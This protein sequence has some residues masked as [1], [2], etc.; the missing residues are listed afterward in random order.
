MSKPSPYGIL[1][2]SLFGEV[3]DVTVTLAQGNFKYEVLETV[4]DE[5][6]IGGPPVPRSKFAAGE[7]VYVHYKIRND[8]EV[9]AKATIVVTDVDTGIEVTRYMSPNVDPGWRFE[10]F[11]ATVGVMPNRDWILRFAMTP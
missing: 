4:G 8:G 10:V 5:S 9:K 3:R 7:T 2:E 1:Y 6:P 11:K